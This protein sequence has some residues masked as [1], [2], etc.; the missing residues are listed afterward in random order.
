MPGDIGYILVRDTP[1][2][3][4]EDAIPLVVD[5]VI[6]NCVVVHT[7]KDVVLFVHIRSLRIKWR[8]DNHVHCAKLRYSRRVDALIFISF[9]FSLFVYCHRRRGRSM[10]FSCRNEYSKF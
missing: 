4:N 1:T 8:M 5:V 7:A 6:I 10:R 3:K 9:F 2:E